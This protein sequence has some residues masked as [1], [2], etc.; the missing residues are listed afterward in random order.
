MKWKFICESDAKPSKNYKGEV[1]GT[2][3]KR[4]L[5]YDKTLGRVRVYRKIFSEQEKNMKVLRFRTE[6]EAKAMCDE[7]NGAYND[8]FKVGVLN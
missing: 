4:A 2:T 8:D 6:Q 7:I 1:I 5:F 3:E